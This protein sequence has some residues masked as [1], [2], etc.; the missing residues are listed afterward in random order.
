MQHAI[1]HTSIQH[2]CG[3]SLWEEAVQGWQEYLLSCRDVLHCFIAHL[4]MQTDNGQ[5]MIVYL[6]SLFFLS[7]VS[8]DIRAFRE[9][10]ITLL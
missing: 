9:R 2:A 10:M 3:V 4:S 1:D 8:F 7:D 6:A 5:Q